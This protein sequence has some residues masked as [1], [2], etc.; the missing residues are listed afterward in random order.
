MGYNFRAQLKN[1]EKQNTMILLIMIG[2]ITRL[3]K[4]VT[5]IVGKPFDELSSALDELIDNCKNNNVRYMTIEDSI[6]G[7]CKEVKDMIHGKA[8]KPSWNK[9]K[10]E[11]S[12]YS[13]VG[14]R[15]KDN[16]EPI[17]IRHTDYCEPLAEGKKKK[18]G[19]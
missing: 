5:K 11:I 14:L 9:F 13:T 19:T 8:T 15:N 3:W 10:E 7:S 18:Y 4:Q 6:V 1:V 12:Q 17:Y 2:M 16:K